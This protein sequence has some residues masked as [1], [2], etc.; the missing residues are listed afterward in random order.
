MTGAQGALWSCIVGSTN[1]PGAK[2]VMG[3]GQGGDEQL[4]S[5]SSGICMGSRR[6]Y[7]LTL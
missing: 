3:W 5:S 1:H 6:C 2:T 7:F 4:P